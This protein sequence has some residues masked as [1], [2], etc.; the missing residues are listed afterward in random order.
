[1]CVKIV[2]GLN[3]QKK[4]SSVYERGGHGLFG[5]RDS[6]SWVSDDTRTWSL[7]IPDMPWSWRKAIDHHFLIRSPLHWHLI[8]VAHVEDGNP[9]SVEILDTQIVGATKQHGGGAHIWTP[10]RISS[11]LQRHM[12]GLQPIRSIAIGYCG[13]WRHAGIANVK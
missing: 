5:D 10:A 6:L 12:Q 2:L 7:C 1:M 11:S 8:A 3:S 13:Q 4:K 9:M